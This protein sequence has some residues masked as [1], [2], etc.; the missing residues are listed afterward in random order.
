MK[1]KIVAI[2]TVLCIISL[3]AIGTAMQANNEST[4]TLISCILNQKPI[5]P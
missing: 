3:I 5:L 4:Q 2:L 1:R